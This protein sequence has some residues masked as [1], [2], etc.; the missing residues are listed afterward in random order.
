MNHSRQC[1]GI[2]ESTVGRDRS[3][4]VDGEAIEIAGSHGNVLA[5]LDLTGVVDRGDSKTRGVSRP[6]IGRMV[7]IGIVRIGL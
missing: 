5:Y 3:A 2:H 6:G 4:V 7:S 1:N